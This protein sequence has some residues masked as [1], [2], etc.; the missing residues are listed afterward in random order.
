MEAKTNQASNASVSAEA[1]LVRELFAR[2]LD[3]PQIVYELTGVKTSSGRNYQEAART[4]Q[5]LLRSAI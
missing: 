4:V 5:Q 3:I 2:G 1:A